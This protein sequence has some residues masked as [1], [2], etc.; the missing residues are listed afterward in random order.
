MAKFNIPSIP[1]GRGIYGNRTLNLRSVKAIG[2]DMDY[3]LIHYFSDSWEKKAYEHVKTKLLELNLPVKGLEYIPNFSVRGLILDLENGNLV[4]ANRFGYVKQAFHGTKQMPFD[5]LRATYSRTLIDLSETRFK[6]LNTFFSLSEACMF[7]QLVDLMDEH[8]FMGILGYE[9]LYK[10]VNRALDEAHA[11]GILKEEILS[12]PDSYIEFDEGTI[13][14]IKDQRLAGKKTMLITNSEWNYTRDIMVHAFDRFL[15]DGETWRDLFDLI[16]VGARKPAFFNQ[17]TPAYEIVNEEGMLK[18]IV[19]GLKEGQMYVGGNAGLVEKLW[20][21]RGEEI[22]YVGDHIFAD[23]TVSKNILR[24]RTALV[25]RELEEELA[26]LESFEA[27]QKDLSRLMLE[28]MELEHKQNHY[29][30]EMVRGKKSGKNWRKEMDEIRKQILDLDGQISPLAKK[31]STLMNSRWGLIM[32]AG[33]D[34]SHMARQIE[35]NAD[36]YMSRVS[37]FAFQTPYV[38]LRSPRSSLPHDTLE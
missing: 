32:R 3:T 21:L 24:W 17:T 27:D 9:D 38:Y 30:M 23:V 19:G 13:Q 2:Y 35:K 28:K 31:Y 26:H 6:F 1:A 15:N 4:K 7:A 20:G 10:K 5:E 14:A 29:R 25:V 22:L 8:K 16:I 18:P 33:N 37:N 11:E 34:K 12:D 36:V